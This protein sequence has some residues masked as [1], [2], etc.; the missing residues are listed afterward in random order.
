MASRYNQTLFSRINSGVYSGVAGGIGAGTSVIAVDSPDG[1]FRRNT[2]QNAR[3]YNPNSAPQA[4]GGD[5][6]ADPREASIIQ[7]EYLTQIAVREQA[8][9]MSQKELQDKE[10][11]RKKLER[12]LQGMLADH[13][14]DN[15]L[16]FDPKEVRLKTYGSLA[17]GFAVQGSDMDLLLYFPQDKGPLGPIEILARRMLERTLL[18]MGFGARLL[19]ETRVPIM[20]VCQN[21]DPDLLAHL[22]RYRK[23]WDDEEAARA[24]KDNDENSQDRSARLPDESLLDNTTP[25][26]ELDIDPA[27]VPLPPSPSRG[28]A[29]LEF[30]DQLV[31]IRCDI[32]FSNYVA[33]HNTSLLRAYC[34]CDHRVR[35]MGLLV[36]A[37]AKARKINTPYHGTLSSY[38]YVMMVLHYLMN[39]AQPPVIQN[40]QIEGHRRL[41]LK[42]P[43][44][45]PKMCEGHDVTFMD[46]EREIIRLASQGRLTRNQEVLGSL[47]RGFFRYYSDYRGFNWVKS[48]I[49]IR[50]FGGELQKT[51]KGWTEAKWTGEKQTIRQRYLLAIEDPFEID[52]NI[53]RTVGHS[54]IVAIRDEFRRA[55]DILNNIAYIPGAGWQW[56][57]KDGSLGDDLFAPVHD[58]G[59]LHRKDEDFHRERVRKQKQEADGKND[60]DRD[61]DTASLTSSMQRVRDDDTAS[62]DTQGSPC[63]STSVGAERV[64]GKSHSQKYGRAKSPS[65]FTRGKG[66]EDPFLGEN[67]AVAAYTLENRN[68]S[69]VNLD[70]RTAA[71]S[72]SKGTFDP[73]KYGRPAL[74]NVVPI[75]P[76]TL[77][78]PPPPA[79]DAEPVLALTYRPIRPPTLPIAHRD[80]SVW[81][82]ANTTL[83]PAQLR[84]LAVIARG[85]NGCIRSGEDF[86]SSWGGA[87]RMGTPD[88]RR[89]PRRSKNKNDSNVNVEQEW[90]DVLQNMRE[91]RLRGSAFGADAMSRL[92]LEW[93]E[94]SA[95]KSLLDELPTNVAGS[96][97]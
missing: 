94:A 86:E 7:T 66:M 4:P 27:E 62:I 6:Q 53:A 79:N 31:G 83:D 44:L 64:S 14:K 75:S 56:R 95:D 85:G 68:E 10:N 35:E 59:D 72:S 20:Q 23:D 69:F 91:D 38:G 3:L 65:P 76:P 29:V 1:S 40:L 49:S 58:R 21:P 19:T 89:F 63:N 33:I 48:V 96:D 51:S 82:P 46:D 67:K 54:G 8:Q 17:S 42:N 12:I 43:A 71:N 9:T 11:F 34:K 2:P 55:A 41:K 92:A 13:A 32:N 36:K 77:Q 57:K 25:F 74:K 61:K 60:S 26:A 37:W 24:A 22:Q 18:D 47:L 84:D 39:V 88:K 93:K 16:P 81:R 87:G 97:A 90:T 30:S 52:H 73:S 28:R 78:T 50:S 80:M 15:V 5:Q 45:P 70:R